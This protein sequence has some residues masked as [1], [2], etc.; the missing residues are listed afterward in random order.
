MN[1]KD[2]VIITLVNDDFAKLHFRAVLR[3]L[4]ETEEEFVRDL[5][6]VI[7]NYY[8]ALVGSGSK[9]AKYK[10]MFGSLKPIYDFHFG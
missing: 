4:I 6:Y 3:E 2:E 8:K 7:D 1:I 9:L 10:D 5:G